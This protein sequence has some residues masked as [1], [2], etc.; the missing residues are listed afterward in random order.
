LIA[1]HYLVNCRINKQ[2]PDYKASIE[3]ENFLNSLGFQTT[4]ERKFGIAA[5]MWAA[6]KASIGIIR[7][8]NFFY[9]NKRVHGFILKLG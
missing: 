5:L 6:Y 8:K 1:K 3:F 7:K 4:T 2:S 9:T